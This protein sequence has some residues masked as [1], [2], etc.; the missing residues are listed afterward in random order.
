MIKPG[1]IQAIANQKIVRDT[2]IEKDYIITWVLMGLSQNDYLKEALL[3]KGGTALKKAYYPD[4]RFSEDLDFTFVGD[5]FDKDR[6]LNT[7]EEAFEWIYDESRI[8]LAIKEVSELSIG[9]V[10]FYTGYIGP[11]G[12]DGSKKDLKVDISQDEKV[13]YAPEFRSI[14]AEYSDAEGNFVCK[15]YS[16]GRSFLK[17]C[18]L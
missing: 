17:R 6:I 8:K 2:Q 18:G 13:Y 4:Y 1:E 14:H 5:G 10:N 16:L 9:N 3:F 15:C 7:F 11:L 12:G